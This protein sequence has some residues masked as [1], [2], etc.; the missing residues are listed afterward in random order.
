[1]NT[2]ADLMQVKKKKSFHGRFRTPRTRSGCLR[3]R[4]RKLKCDGRENS[5]TLKRGNLLICM[6]YVEQK[7]RCVRC[8]G[9]NRSCQ[10]G[11]K[12]TWKDEPLS[13]KVMLRRRGSIGSILRIII[14]PET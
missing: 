13:K 1:M 11:L 7:P 10:Y 2:H 14:L 9:S 4:R 8:C 6:C 12:F 3:C 5:I